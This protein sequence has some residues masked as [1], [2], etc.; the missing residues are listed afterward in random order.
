MKSFFRNLIRVEWNI[1]FVENSEDL[2]EREKLQIH[3]MK[4]SYSKGWFADPFILEVTETEIILL[5]EEYQYLSDLGCISKLV[6]ERNSFKLKSV[7]R[8]L[9]IESHLSFP[10]IFKYENQLYIYPENCQMGKLKLYSYDK[11]TD[12]V[13]PLSVWCE[14]PL[15]DAALCICSGRPFLFSTKR[16]KQNGADLDIYASVG[17]KPSEWSFYHAQTVHFKDNVARNA[18]LSFYW[19]NE[20]MRPA[21]DCNKGYGKGIVIQNIYQDESG[22]T[23]KE[24]KRFFPS[25]LKWKEGLH[26]FN[27]YNEIIVVDG[28]RYPYPMFARIYRIVR[29][30]IKIGSNKLKR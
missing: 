2:L 15:T 5:V 11:I 21:Q 1:G 27:V 17:E 3:W 29:Y 26:T 6:V 14:E 20:L 9:Q 13:T 18:G 16:P 25:S 24:V 19:K 12:I 8:I 28:R 10:A 4:H 7:K 22:F 30:F 23:F